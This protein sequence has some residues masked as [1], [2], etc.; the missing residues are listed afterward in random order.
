MTLKPIRLGILL[1]LITILFGYSLGAVF[2]AANSTMKNY[3]HEQVY[4]VHADNF[5]SDKDKGTAFSK[6]KELA[7]QTC[8][9]DVPLHLKNATSSITRD[10]GHGSEYRYAHNEINAFA[11]GENYFPEAL[12]QGDS[13]HTRL[14]EPTERGL[15]KQLKEK[16]DYLNQL[17]RN[18]NDQ[19][20]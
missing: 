15:E 14:Y 3:F 18:S 20:Y 9:L 17:N 5:H 12:A 1:S 8:D 7:K 2:G 4:V 13:S 16:L 19:R 11:A 10:M 6:A